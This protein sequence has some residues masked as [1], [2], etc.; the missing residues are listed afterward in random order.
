MQWF[1]QR[2]N[3]CFDKAE[4]CKTRC[5]DD[6]PD[7]ARFP[8]KLVYDRAL[9]ISRAAAVNELRGEAPGDCETAYETALWM[10]YAI[11]DETMSASTPAIAG[12][13]AGV[14]YAAAAGG[15]GGMLIVD[16]ADRATVDKFIASISARLNALKRKIA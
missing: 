10:L 2:F 12:D 14:P 15:G 16:E 4:F 6:M 8:E 11:L 9:E 1:R 5:G 7:S 13:S 3:D